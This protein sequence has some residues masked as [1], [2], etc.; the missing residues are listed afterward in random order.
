VFNFPQ[1]HK[2]KSNKQGGFV[3][4]TPRPPRSPLHRLLILLSSK[5]IA[6][7]NLVID[8]KFRAEKGQFRQSKLKEKQIH[9]LKVHQ[10]YNPLFT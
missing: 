3:I 10:C 7:K 8:V 6:M 1:D 4:N 9:L 2:E 5:T